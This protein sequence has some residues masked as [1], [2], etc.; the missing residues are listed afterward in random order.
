MYCLFSSFGILSNS[1]QSC[2]F[3]RLSVHIVSCMVDPT[4]SNPPVIRIRA[5]KHPSHVGHEVLRGVL[6]G[7]QILVMPRC[8]RKALSALAQQDALWPLIK[9][10]SWLVGIRVPHYDVTDKPLLNCHDLG[11]I[12]SKWLIWWKQHYISSLRIIFCNRVRV[13][14]CHSDT[15]GIIEWVAEFLVCSYLSL[16]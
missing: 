8:W 16:S 12:T 11:K 6:Q 1:D 13:I 4:L 3:M 10:S 15:A 5:A 14:T 2:S 9:K 7:S